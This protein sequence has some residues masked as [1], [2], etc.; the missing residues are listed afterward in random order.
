M[1]GGGVVKPQDVGAH[2]YIAFKKHGR[3][4]RHPSYKDGDGLLSRQERKHVGLELKRQNSDQPLLKIVHNPP[5]RK[6]VRKPSESY[7]KSFRER[8]KN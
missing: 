7:K 5:P 8:V 6:M 2:S 1:R 4:H 3:K